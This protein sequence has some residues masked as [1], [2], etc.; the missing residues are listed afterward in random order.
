MFK[1]D[2]GILS[3]EV[4][5]L[6]AHPVFPRISFKF[7]IYIVIAATV[8]HYMSN[9]LI[10][11]TQ[12]TRWRPYTIDTFERVFGLTIGYIGVALIVSIIVKL[13]WNTFCVRAFACPRIQYM[14]AFLIV[15]LYHVLTAAH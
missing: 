7:G 12:V 4:K 3:E 6:E 2:S 5:P 15:F 1:Q 9:I 10:W 14:H 8:F 11:W 13:V